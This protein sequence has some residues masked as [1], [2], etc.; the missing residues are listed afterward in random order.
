MESGQRRKENE[1][2]L[3]GK[4]QPTPKY[5]PATKRTPEYPEAE[6]PRVVNPGPFRPKERKTISH[7]DCNE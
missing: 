4:T 1:D 3:R 5:E 2:A 7:V 6:H